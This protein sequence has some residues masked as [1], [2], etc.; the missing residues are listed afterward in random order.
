MRTPI[1]VDDIAEVFAR[2]AMTEKPA[3]AIYNSG[4]TAISL[5]ELAGMVRGFL[6]D[7]RI[8]FENETGGR[9]I[10]SNYLIDNR[11]LVEEFG[12]QY[13][14]LRPARPSDHQRSPRRGGRAAHC[15]RLRA[16]TVHRAQ[17]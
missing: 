6:P 8:S 11:R 14:P 1:H 13:P 2:V 10:S 16:Q 3:H 9:E 4:G 5:G 7:A 17:P 12:M 15:R